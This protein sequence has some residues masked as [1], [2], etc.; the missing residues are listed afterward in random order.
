MKLQ[1]KNKRLSEEQRAET[2]RLRKIANGELPTIEREV[3]G[4]KSVS[5]ALIGGEQVDDVVAAK[6]VNRALCLFANTLPEEEALSIAAVFPEWDLGIKYKKD[7]Y[8]RY[9]L[10]LYGEPQIYRVI[11]GHKSQYDWS[12][13]KSPALFK[14]VGF[15]G[16]GTP[17]WVQPMG[18]TDAYDKGDI[19]LHKG[20][21]YVSE[22]NKNVWEPGVYG[23]LVHGETAP[24]STVKKK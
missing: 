9:G 17:L 7:E 19:V 20:V 21:K 12:P 13:E 15:A 3:D 18:A 10:N 2:I 14:K 5:S 23:W 6:Q 4:L 24:Q 16:D 11:Q 1:P 8:L 22:I